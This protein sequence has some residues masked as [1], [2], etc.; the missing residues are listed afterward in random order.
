MLAVIG[1]RF[2]LPPALSVGPDWMLAPVLTVLL[3]SSVVLYRL[4]HYR[5]NQIVG[6]VLLATVTTDMIASLTLLITR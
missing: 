4:G 2:A 3:V 6:Y 1:L 5:A